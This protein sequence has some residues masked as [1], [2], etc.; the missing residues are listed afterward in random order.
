MS[1]PQRR[2]QITDRTLEQIRLLHS[3]GKTNPEIASELGI[4]VSSVYN[5]ARRLGLQRSWK[6]GPRTDWLEI[7]QYYDE[8]HSLRECE[9]K[10]G[11]SRRSWN[12]A[13]ARGVIVPRPQAMPLE[14]LLV[15]GTARGRQNIKSRLIAAGLKENRCERC[16]IDQWLGAPLNMALHHVN[17]DRDDNRLENLELLC[18]NCHSQT[19]NFGRRTGRLRTRPEV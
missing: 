7:Q 6:Y 4:S 1:E 13:V 3:E 19:P 11:F 8:G 9:Q 2:S 5:H 10:F 14:I 16:G 15:A 18:N 17:G 12:K